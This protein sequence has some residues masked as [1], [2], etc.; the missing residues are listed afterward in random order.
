M[1]KFIYLIVALLLVG[2]AIALT[3]YRAESYKN[4][5]NSLKVYDSSCPKIETHQ[6]YYV[7]QIMVRTAR[8]GLTCQFP[9]GNKKSVVTP[10]VRPLCKLVETCELVKD[11][12]LKWNVKHTVCK[13]WSYVEECTSTKVC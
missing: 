13:K 12:C 11:E 9:S 10:V 5:V 2:S 7:Q 1:K 8:D 3:D 4:R 6:G